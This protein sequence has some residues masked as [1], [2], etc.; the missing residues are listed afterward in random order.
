MSKNNI[1]DLSL[2][3]LKKEGMIMDNTFL[4]ITFNCSNSNT[5]KNEAIIQLNELCDDAIMEMESYDMST[6]L[7]SLLEVQLQHSYCFPK[8]QKLLFI[9]NIQLTGIEIY[10]PANSIYLGYIEPFLFN[11]DDTKS[12]IIL[13]VS[14]FP[15]IKLNF[16]NQTDMKNKIITMTAGLFRYSFI[17]ILLWMVFQIYQH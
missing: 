14:Q 6:D 16:K 12:M 9:K 10:D 1:T 2:R 8:K 5:I 13:K 3:R 11:D 7:I 15:R 17:Q 4:E